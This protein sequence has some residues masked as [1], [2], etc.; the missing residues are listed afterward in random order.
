M[1]KHFGHK[2]GHEREQKRL[3]RSAGATGN[4]GDINITASDRQLPLE[5]TTGVVTSHATGFRGI[6]SDSS[7]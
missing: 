3:V 5:A 4:S 6:Q 1:T 7:G 2:P